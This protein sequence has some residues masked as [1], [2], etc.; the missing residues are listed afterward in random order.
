MAIFTI[1]AIA[2]LAI[3][4]MAPAMADTPSS[5]G[6]VLLSWVHQYPVASPIVPPQGYTLCAQE[7]PGDNTH[8]MGLFEACFNKP[9]GSSGL[10][11]TYTPTVPGSSLFC[12]DLGTR[13]AIYGSVASVAPTSAPAIAQSFSIDWKQEQ[14]PS[15]FETCDP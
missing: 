15:W 4:T 6:A 3:C 7:L 12:R 14:T 5:K 2:A 8:R 9:V 1:A 10:T 11:L 13:V